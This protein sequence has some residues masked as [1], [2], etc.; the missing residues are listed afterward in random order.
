MKRKITLPKEQINMLSRIIKQSKH[1][2]VRMRAHFII[3]YAAGH[4]MR[5]LA[6]IF[7]VHQNTV[8]NWLNAW[9][10]DGLA[11][12]YNKSGRGRPSILTAEE[13][14]R[15]KEEVKKHPQKAILVLD[16]IK[17]ELG[18]TISKE[19]L[20]RVLKS[21][22]MTWHR[23]R[24]V[25]SGKPDEEDYKQK[26]AALE[27]LKESEKQGDLTIYYMDESGFSL[28]PYVP[29]CWQEKGEK[30]E[31]PS[32]KS[33]GLN[34][35]GFLNKDNDLKAYSCQGSIDSKL[36]ITFI[37]HFVKTIT[38]PTVVV[39]DNAPIHHA[40]IFAEKTAEWQQKGLEIF[41]LP[42]YSPQ[43]NLIEILWKKIKYEWL[44]INAYTSWE[45]LVESVENVIRNVGTEFT[46]NFE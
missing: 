1:H 37:D 21:V 13:K 18:K 36:V 35:L 23:A 42:T 22:G 5:E 45:S 39:I 27:K 44:S 26:K 19:T 4:L 7:K 12:L 10:S 43:L 41:F 32:K 34:I 38:A 46:I 6:R 29:Y 25:M 20:K 33:A 2:Q 30:V 15:V 11:G 40:K 16:W 17:K 24:R 8:T 3:L 14:Q 9:F 28:T 31:L